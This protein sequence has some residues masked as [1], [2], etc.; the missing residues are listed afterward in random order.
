[1]TRVYQLLLWRETIISTSA[2]DTA[3]LQ[4]TLPYAPPEVVTAYQQGQ[5]TI[6]ASAATDI[7]A[8][9]VIAYE[10]LTREVWH[11]GLSQQQI[12]E[13]IS[14]EGRLPWEAAS[15]EARSELRRTLRKKLQRLAPTVLN[16]LTRDVAQRPTASVLVASLEGI[17]HATTT[18][19]TTV[20]APVLPH[21]SLL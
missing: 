15:P 19:T 18:T 6:V 9:G 8:L 7:W 12:T 20:K 4:F 1:M 5:H 11:Q 16:C 14:T 3:P 10:L 17:Y 2:G 21:T 13:A